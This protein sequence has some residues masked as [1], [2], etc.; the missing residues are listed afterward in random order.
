MT[1][2]TL[3]SSPT[4]PFVQRA[5]IALKEK[6]VEFEVIY[7]DL[8]D[9]PA[10]FLDIS[11]LGKVPLLR[12]EHDGEPPAVIFESAVILEYLEETVP[13]D[14]LHPA[15]PL[16]RAQHRAWIEFGSTVLGDLHRYA[17]AQDGAALAAAREV[18][19]GKLKRLE[20]TIVGAPYFAGQH[21]SLVDAAF[22]PVFRQIDALETVATTG[23]L[24][25]FPG[26]ERW[27]KALAARESVRTA[28]P[29]DYVERYLGRLRKLDAEVL[30]AAWA[31]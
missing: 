28:V 14:K 24:D 30:R 2:L 18:L 27:R 6:H 16:R 13:G 23:L 21:F 4:C 17:T 26:L 29:A 10:W 5:V 19:R 31:A 12:I 7:V 11:P 3:I 1:K 9:K 22:G 15:D 8:A 25:G 20:S